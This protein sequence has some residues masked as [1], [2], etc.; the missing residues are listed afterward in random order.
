MMGEYRRLVNDIVVVGGAVREFVIPTPRARS[1][2]NAPAPCRRPPYFS[3]PPP[4]WKSPA[5]LVICERSLQSTTRPRALELGLGLALELELLLAG[6]ERKL[7][8]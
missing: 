1:N 2:Y 8:A 6:G 5:H 3:I 4:R 7:V